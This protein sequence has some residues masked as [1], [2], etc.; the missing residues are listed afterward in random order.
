MRRK[1]LIPNPDWWSSLVLVRQPPPLGPHP[2]K[3]AQCQQG[4]AAEYPLQ[5]YIYAEHE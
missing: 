4:H 2:R 5:I 3:V 1:T